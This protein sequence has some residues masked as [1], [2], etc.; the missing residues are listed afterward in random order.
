MTTTSASIKAFLFVFLFLLVILVNF[1]AQ[2]P[3]PS[4][5]TTPE[6]SPS[7]SPS[8]SPTP[9]RAPSPTPLPGAQNFHQWGSVT[10]FNGLPSDSV[11]AIAQ[12][13]DGVMWFGTDNG[14]ARF[15]GR[16]VQNFLPGGAETNRILA[17]KSS[18]SGDLWIGTNTGAF[19]YSNARFRPVRGTESFGV[20]A[21]S[22]GSVTSL[23]TDAG[24]VL[25]VTS[26]EGDL[27]SAA[28]M[29]PEPIRLGDG[30]PLSIT[31][32]LERDR[33][34]LVSTSGLG[35]FAVEDGRVA[36][37]ASSPRPLFVNSL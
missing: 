35:V 27:L 15:D 4:P 33:K 6:A 21:I 36:E 19:V 14:L 24:L 12:T 28:A 26:E 3:Q 18:A 22:T 11:R 31:G 29:F 5:A 37:H 16:R 17:L 9:A 13:P 30:T 25:R 8:P 32:V 20:T 34:L 1:L 7:P 10:V 23:G 2:T